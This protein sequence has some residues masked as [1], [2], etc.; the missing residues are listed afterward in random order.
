M[1][2][3]TY[4]ALCSPIVIRRTTFRNRL[5]SSGHVPGYTPEGHPNDRYVAYNAEK[6]KGGIGFPLFFP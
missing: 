2:S 1:T 5:F 4:R 6:A 3:T